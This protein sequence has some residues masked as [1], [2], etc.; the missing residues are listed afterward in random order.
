MVDLIEVLL[1]LLIMGEGKVIWLEFDKM[2]AIQ[3]YKILACNYTVGH[4]G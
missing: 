4:Y 3:H 1:V 2:N